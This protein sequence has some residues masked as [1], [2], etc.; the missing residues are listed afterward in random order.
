[1]SRAKEHRKERRERRG[2]LAELARHLACNLISRC[3]ETKKT[4]LL[5]LGRGH[6]HALRSL[7]RLRHGLLLEK[8][9]ELYKVV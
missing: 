4:F 7:G 9:I 1:M 2:G 6:G 3:C 5:L 8:K